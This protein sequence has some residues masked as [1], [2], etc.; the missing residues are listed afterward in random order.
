MRLLQRKFRAC[1]LKCVA[2]RYGASTTYRSQQQTDGLSEADLV[3]QLR[4]NAALAALS[5]SWQ[6]T[7]SPKQYPETYALEVASAALAVPVRS[8]HAT[9]PQRRHKKSQESDLQR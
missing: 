5:C 7:R 8:W 3:L 4:P 1:M 6:A 2:S 9:R